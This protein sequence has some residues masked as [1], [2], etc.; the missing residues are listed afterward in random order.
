VTE[1]IAGK[2]I[3]YT[4]RYE[5]YEGDSL[6]T[7]ELFEDR[8]KTRLRLT[9]SGLHTFPANVPDLAKSNFE[10][11]WNQIVGESLRLWLASE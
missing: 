1:V 11:G 3:A 7:W 4:W 6:V 5:G 8:G 9:H 2:R 10:M